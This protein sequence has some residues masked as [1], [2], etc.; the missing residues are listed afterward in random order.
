MAESQQDSE[1]CW[2]TKRQGKWVN[3]RRDRMMGSNKQAGGCHRGA[4]WGIGEIDYWD[5]FH[6]KTC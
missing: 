5:R 3:D 1:S 6:V 4:G 2:N